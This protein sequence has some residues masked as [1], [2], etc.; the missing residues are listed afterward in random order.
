[1]RG[2][3]VWYVSILLIDWLIDW[4]IDLLINCMHRQEMRSRAG[5]GGGGAVVA[6]GCVPSSRP[7]TVLC[8]CHHHHQHH[9]QA[10]PPSDAYQLVMGVQPPDQPQ[11]LSSSQ[12][13]DSMLYHD[14][15][16][17]YNTLCHDTQVWYTTLYH[18]TKVQHNTYNCIIYTLIIMH[19]TLF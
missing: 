5:G 1:M 12:A 13:C 16:V 3:P 10:L 2:K 11:Q 17:W 15:K 18:D 7:A 14:T 19:W 4:L 9:N 6:N 8:Q